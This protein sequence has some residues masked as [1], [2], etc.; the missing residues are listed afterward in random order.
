[1]VV[2]SIDRWDLTWVNTFNLSNPQTT[3]LVETHLGAL[4]SMYADSIYGWLFTQK[5]FVLI[6]PNYT[7]IFTSIY[8]Q[9]Y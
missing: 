5:T 3:H 9:R 6:M 1:M 2:P 7:Y 4:L 8:D